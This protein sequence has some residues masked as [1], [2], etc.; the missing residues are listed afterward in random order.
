VEL[1]LRLHS[2]IRHSWR[3]AQLKEKRRDDFA[4]APSLG[5]QCLSDLNLRRTT[6]RGIV[7]VGAMIP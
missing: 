4:L 2:L 6:V 5:I 7:R 3:G 1:Y